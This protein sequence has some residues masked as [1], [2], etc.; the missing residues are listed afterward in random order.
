M[1][2][3]STIYFFEHFTETT[4]QREKNVNYMKRELDRIHICIFSG[5]GRELL[6]QAF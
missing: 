1:Y 2:I 6:N 4:P 3:S 5:S